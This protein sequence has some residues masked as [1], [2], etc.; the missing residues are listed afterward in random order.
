MMA[1]I[2]A[3]CASFGLTVS[4]AK[5]ETMY[6]MTKSMNSVT[7]VTEAAGQVYKHTTKFGYLVGN[8][9]QKC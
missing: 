6:L 7:C 1:V 3:V 5:T 8:C 9:V 4:E 2:V